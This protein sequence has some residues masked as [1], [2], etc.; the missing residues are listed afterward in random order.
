MSAVK[1]VHSQTSC[2]RVVR[3]HVLFVSAKYFINQSR[4][5]NLVAVLLEAVFG[6]LIALGLRY[7]LRPFDFESIDEQADVMVT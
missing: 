7:C 1:I 2:S 5:K 4:N 3:L 6:G